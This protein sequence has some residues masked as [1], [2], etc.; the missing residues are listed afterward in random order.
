MESTNL[1]ARTKAA[2]IHAITAALAKMVGRLGAVSTDL[3]S[4]RRKDEVRPDQRLTIL[5][6]CEP[7][8]AHNR[9]YTVDARGH[10]ETVLQNREGISASQAS[11]VWGLM[12]DLWEQMPHSR[13][14]VSPDPEDNSELFADGGIRTAAGGRLAPNGYIASRIAALAECIP[15]AAVVRFKR[16]HSDR[17]RN[18][19]EIVDVHG[20]MMLCTDA[21]AISD[22]LRRMVLAMDDDES[23]HLRYR[24]AAWK[25]SLAV[26]ETA[27]IQTLDVLGSLVRFGPV[28]TCYLQLSGGGR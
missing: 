16:I 26:D 25:V 5:H 8:R 21:S 18:Y 24:L 28:D 1:K 20:G 2:D 22:S 3:M 23:R 19:M 17:Q 6:A 15:D 13:I 7:G 14:C 27:L 9:S 12:R 11:Q 4:G 10:A